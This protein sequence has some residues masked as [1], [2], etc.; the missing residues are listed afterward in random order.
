[1]LTVHISG[2]RIELGDDAARAL[3]DELWK[4]L[5]PGAVTAAT[6]VGQ[7]LVRKPAAHRIVQV[8]AT[9]ERAVRSALDALSDAR[10]GE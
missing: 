7:A 5:V 10:E 2:D 9:E 3:A 4:G 6:K 1:V 8:E